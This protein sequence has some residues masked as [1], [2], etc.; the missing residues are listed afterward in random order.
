M[1]VFSIH[2]PGFSRSPGSKWFNSSRSRR[3]QGRDGFKLFRGGRKNKSCWKVA[4]PGITST[5]QLVLTQGGRLRISSDRDD[6][7]RAKIKTPKN[8]WTKNEPAKK[9]QISEPSKIS[10]SIKWYKTKNKVLKT[11]LVEKCAL[12]AEI[13]VHYHEFSDCFEYLEQSILTSKKFR[14]VCMEILF[15]WRHHFSTL[16]R[17]DQ[18]HWPVRPK[19][20][21]ELGIDQDVTQ[22][23]LVF[24]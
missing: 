14:R 6:R 8:P 9:W 13:R 18:K 21:Y 11:S 17:W 15:S 20:T 22:E 16:W 4:C 3:H 5:L 10:K 7:M 1:F 19:H 24:A 23:E 12:F 2:F